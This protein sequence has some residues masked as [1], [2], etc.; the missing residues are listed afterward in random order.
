MEALVAVGLAGNVVQ[1]AS[2]AGTLIKEANLIRKSGSP[3]SLPKLKEI[4]ESLTSQAAAL[5]KRLKA[6]S[7]TLTEED[8]VRGLFE[9]PLAALV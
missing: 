2:S 5:Q 9:I 3:S 1:F 8:Q 7:A 4:S 6:S